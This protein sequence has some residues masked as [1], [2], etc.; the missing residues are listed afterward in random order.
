ILVGDKKNPN[1]GLAPLGLALTMLGLVFGGSWLTMQAGRLLARLR[2]GPASLL[3]ARR[4][5]DDPRATFRSVS[6]LV[7]AVFVGTL[8]AG[9]VPAAVAAQA[10]PAASP[11]NSVLRLDVQGEPEATATSPGGLLDRLRGFTG[12][13]GLAIHAQP[14]DNPLD[15]PPLD[16]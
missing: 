12:A 10:P 3:A 9:A 2:L 16:V 4:I 14:D 5:A 8:L 15:P 7:L 13:T 11:L 1:A 6:G